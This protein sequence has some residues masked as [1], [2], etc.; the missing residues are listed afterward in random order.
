VKI[1]AIETFELAHIPVT[2]PLVK[3]PM[4]QSVTFLQ[5]K[6]DNGIVGLAQISG[7]MPSATIA[8]IRQDLVPFLQGKDPLETERLM[9]QMLWNF[10]SRA[11]AGV[12]SFAVSAIDV[13]L[14]PVK[15]S[16]PG[17]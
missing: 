14:W 6:T 16:R 7:V 11:H 17:G 12:W 9:H 3:S 10:N 15:Y 5:V 1:A 2:P 13:A 8:F 4:H